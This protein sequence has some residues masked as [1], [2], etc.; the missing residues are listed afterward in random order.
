MYWLEACAR[1]PY[2]FGVKVS[3]TVTHKQG[4]LVG[5]SSFTGNPY[6]GHILAAQMEQ[7]F[8]LASKT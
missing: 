3:V 5:A 2:D 4:L 7:R 8:I 6:N 1:K